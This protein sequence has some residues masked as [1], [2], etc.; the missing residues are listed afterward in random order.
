MSEA[1]RATILDL[2]RP[3]NPRLVARERVHI[4][5]T[6]GRAS[7]PARRSPTDRTASR[8]PARDDNRPGDAVGRSVDP[9]PDNGPQ[10][11]LGDHVHRTRSGLAPETPWVR[12]SSSGSTTP[13]GRGA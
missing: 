3:P 2:A 6:I 7:N 9:P 5:E 13:C 8:L 12:A 4:G 10:P 11:T 1:K